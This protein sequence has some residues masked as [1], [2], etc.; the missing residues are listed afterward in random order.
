MWIV[1]YASSGNLS[2]GPLLRL[3]RGSFR[4]HSARFRPGKWMTACTFLADVGCALAAQLRAREQAWRDEH[5]TYKEDTTDPFFFRASRKSRIRRMRV[6]ERRTLAR[7]A[8]HLHQTSIRV[9]QRAPCV[10]CWR[11]TCIWRK[12]AHGVRPVL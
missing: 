4:S 2:C 10:N 1:K 3:V 9:G 8:R 6:P 11:G 7:R 5:A 12:G